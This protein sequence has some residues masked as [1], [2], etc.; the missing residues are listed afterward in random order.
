MTLAVDQQP[1]VA[2]FIDTYKFDQDMANKRDR[3]GGGTVRLIY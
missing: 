1:E 3:F 2:R